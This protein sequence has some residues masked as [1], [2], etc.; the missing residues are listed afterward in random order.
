MQCSGH[1]STKHASS[2]YIYKHIYTSTYYVATCTLHTKAQKV[3]QIDTH[4]SPVTDRLVG[5]AGDRPRVAGVVVRRGGGEA[6]LLRAQLLVELVDELLRLQVHQPGPG[7]LAAVVPDR[8]RRVGD[9]EL[10]HR[11]RAAAAEAGAPQ[12]RRRRRAT[13]RRRRPGAGRCC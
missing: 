13:A 6:L 11:R 4:A 5:D 12:R 8:E 9:P 2:M 10:P 1:F 3:V 7:V